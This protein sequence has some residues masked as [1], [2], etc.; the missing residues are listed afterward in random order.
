MSEKA[1]YWK[2]KT[3]Y[4]KDLTEK[5]RYWNKIIQWDRNYY[6]KIRYAMEEWHPL[7]IGGTEG[8][9]LIDKDGQKILDLLSGL[10]SVNV[11][12]RHPKV[13]EQIKKALDEY[14]YVWE[15]FTT[16][17]KA[18]AAKLIIEDILG[19]D[20]WAGRVRFVN[21]GSEANEEALILAKLYTN[22]PF[23]ITRAM[24]YH[25]WTE[26]AGACSRIPAWRGTITSPKTKERRVVPTFPAG[27]YFVAP[28]PFCYRCP[29]GHEYPDCKVDGRVACISATE[30]LI[31]SLG[32][33]NV[34][35]II[36]EIICGGALIISPPEYL[37]ELRK[38][39]REHGILWIDDEVMTGFG[40]TG[41]WFAYQHYGVTP[42]I[43]TMAKG[44]SSCHLPAAGVVVSK[45]L[46]EFFEKYR[47]WHAVTFGAHPV[48]MAA[49]VANLK[50]MIEE[51]LP[52]RAAE[53]G[54]YMEPKLKEL[55]ERHKCVGQVSGMGLFWG[56]EIVRNKE[57]KEPFIKEDRYFTGAGDIYN[58]PINKIL[59]HCYFGKNV[60]VSGFV[61]N[62]IRIGPAL[63]ITKEEIDKGIE[64]LDYALSV[65]DS[66]C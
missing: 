21:S 47:W 60:L 41:K 12:Q 40:R 28:P 24:S 59:A 33:D 25:G 1:A 52:E 38:F 31:L 53:M 35:A 39:T 7:P 2:E 44:I 18:E 37:Q 22:R 11:G 23:I 45:D 10:I 54:K 6:L 27:G 49:V 29:F 4:W 42:D 65:I 26:G 34:A 46:A 3:A 64:A 14:S 66:M 51:K 55:E 48:C 20:N 36:T 9:Y 15:V 16:P 13:I 61:P 50:V 58:Y 17:Y 43:M 30:D 57:T 8:P 56:I 5:Q 32:P 62:G 19:P 63:T